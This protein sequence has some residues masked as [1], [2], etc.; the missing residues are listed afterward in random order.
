MVR[1]YI[2]LSHTHSMESLSQEDYGYYV[3]E[4]SWQS[5][6][7]STIVSCLLPMEA[8]SSGALP[9]DTHW[10]FFN[11]SYYP[12]FTEEKTEAQT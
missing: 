10:I 3:I 8:Q 11:R 7:G 9:H 1:L 12:H 4:S 6:E 2:A 5:R